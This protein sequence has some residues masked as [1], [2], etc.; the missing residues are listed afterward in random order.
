MNIDRYFEE[1]EFNLLRPN[2]ELTR[3]MRVFRKG[4]GL[5]I[6]AIKSTIWLTIQRTSKGNSTRRESDDESS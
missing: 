1:T 2:D 5:E 4:D 6:R 3:L